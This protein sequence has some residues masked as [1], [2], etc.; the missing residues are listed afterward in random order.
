[1]QFAKDTATGVPPF[2]VKVAENV[3]EKLPPQGKLGEKLSEITS[4]PQFAGVTVIT[5]PIKAKSPAGLL[6]YASAS[7]HVRFLAAG[8]AVSVALQHPV[9][10]TGPI[11]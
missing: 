1:M 7:A 6:A 2:G 9:I 4:V 5:P 8:Q 10:V 11:L 3:T